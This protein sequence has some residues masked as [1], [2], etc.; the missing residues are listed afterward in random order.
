MQAEVLAATIRTTLGLFALLFVFFRILLPAM[1]ENFRQRIFGLRRELFLYMADG[2]ISPD[3]PAYGQI[4]TTMNY[5]LHTAD[6]L[7]FTRVILS[8]IIYRKY[9][10]GYSE[11][12]DGIMD[13]VTDPEVRARL[14][15]FRVR[16]G[17]ELLSLA[18][19]TSPV[20]II[21]GVVLMFLA[22]AKG[23]LRG[24]NGA[25]NEVIKVASRRLEIVEAEAEALCEAA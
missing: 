7:T 17:R 2:N 4:R 19:F 23:V 24:V 14:Q 1:R 12:I 6:R 25:T 10:E 21:I 18:I 16:V 8:M 3:E 11:R 22:A 5:L 15:D 9:G 20:A 13:R